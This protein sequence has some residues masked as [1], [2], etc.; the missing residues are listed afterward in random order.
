MP[1]RNKKTAQ[2]Y[3]DEEG[4][5]PPALT[6]GHFLGSAAGIVS[7]EDPQAAS[8]AVCCSTRAE[9]QPADKAFHVRRTKKGKL[10]ISLENRAKGKKVTVVANVTGNAEGLLHE[11]KTKVGAGGVVRGDSVEL[12]GDHQGVVER[13]LTGHPAVK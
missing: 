7:Q 8:A 6:L 10:P 4:S 2:K 11:L 12:Q 5:R 3:A 13:F 9:D 1:K